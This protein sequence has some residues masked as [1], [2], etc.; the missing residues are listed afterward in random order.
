MTPSK[1]NSLR[2][3]RIEGELSNKEKREVIEA[4]RTAQENKR[5]IGWLWIE[6]KKNR[7]N[8]KGLLYDENRYKN[9]IKPS[10]GDREPQELV[11]LDIDRVRI[12]LLKKRSPGTVKNALE[13]LRRIINYGAQKNLC[14]P[15]SF[16]IEM[17]KGKSEKTEDLTPGQLKNLLDAIEKDSN[18][19]AANMM[20]MAL[21]TGMR[22]GEL[23][24]LKWNDINF[25]KGFITLRTPKGGTEQ[26][27]PLN[28]ASR[29]LLQGHP[30]EKSE[31]VF[32]GRGG[33]QRKD[34]KHQVN[35]IKAKAGLPKDFRPL[36]GL[37]HVYASMLAS[38]GQVDMYVLQKL[39]THKDGRMTQRYAHLRDETL[40]KASALAGD[41][42][43]EAARDRNQK[44]EAKTA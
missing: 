14:K 19:Q 30:K 10:F 28:E 22:R 33:N 20:K 21:Y 35:R 32:P 16:K 2:T 23:F 8:L 15:L 9:H 39:L 44:D 38:S 7:P 6:Y 34:I 4:E 29:T 43:Q 13:L 37:R 12:N 1:A 18:I 25:D 24:R 40:K 26:K 36:H 31:Y 27:I 3:R 11:P 17:P 42:I 41:I 5:T